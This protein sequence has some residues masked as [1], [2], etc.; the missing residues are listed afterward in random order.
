[1]NIVNKTLYD[2]QLIISYNRY[3]LISYLKTNFLVVSLVSLA[4]IAYM[5]AY[6]MWLYAAILFGIVIVYLGM[7]FLMQYITTKKALKNSTLVDNPVAQTYI[8]TDEGII[9]DNI[10]KSTLPYVEISR[11]KNTNAFFIISDYTK[12]TYI[13]LKSVFAD[14]SEDVDQLTQFFKEKFGKKFR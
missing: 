10:K 8:F 9:I 4:S 14:P 12:R 13:V 11:I 6:Q 2:K 5:I 7:T 3:Y 1:M